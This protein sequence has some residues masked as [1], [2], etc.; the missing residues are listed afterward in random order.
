MKGKDRIEKKYLYFDSH[1]LD[2]ER[3]H[4]LGNGRLRYHK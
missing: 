1:G 2:F 4:E 3:H